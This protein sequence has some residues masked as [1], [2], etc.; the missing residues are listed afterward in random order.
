MDCRRF[1]QWLG[2]FISRKSTGIREPERDDKKDTSQPDSGAGSEIPRVG[3]NLI[4]EFEGLHDLRADGM[5]Y[6]YP[7]PGS[8][9]L[10]IT[11]GWGTTRRRDGSPFYLG[12]KITREEA[13]AIFEEQLKE[14]YW[15]KLKD[16]VPFWDEMSDN[17]KAALLSFAYN[18]GADFY[19]H[20]GFGTISGA[21]RDRRW[22]D[23]PNALALYVMAGGR[24]LAGLVRRRLAEGTLWKK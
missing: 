10:P 16:R 21:L 14:D 13:D 12:D 6:A 15:D 9:G 3:I 20:P 17:Q 11:I 7:D 18:L 24:K 4:K 5:V 22:R 8:G 2:S 1:R 19:G 23:V